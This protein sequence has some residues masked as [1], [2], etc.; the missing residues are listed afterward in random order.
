MGQN[1]VYVTYES[2]VTVETYT[3][4]RVESKCPFCGKRFNSI[5]LEGKPTSQWC[6]WCDRTFYIE[7][8]PE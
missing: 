1:E 8:L 6:D 4:Y 3:E 2:S 5:D 7:Y